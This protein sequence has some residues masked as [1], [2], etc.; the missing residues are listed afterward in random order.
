MP[1]FRHRNK[2]AI[3]AILFVAIAALG[4]LVGDTAFDF[5]L[6]ATLTATVSLLWSYVLD[7]V[8]WS[9]KVLMGADAKKEDT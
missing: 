4:F 7:A 8:V 2:L 3:A 5:L 1:P 6:T 9:V